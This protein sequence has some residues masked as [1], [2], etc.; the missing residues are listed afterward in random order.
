MGHKDLILKFSSETVCLSGYSW[1]AVNLSL[2]A[3][4]RGST[5]SCTCSLYY[6]ISEDEFKIEPKHNHINFVF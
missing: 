6:V 3:C 1:D 5:W 4:F 2:R